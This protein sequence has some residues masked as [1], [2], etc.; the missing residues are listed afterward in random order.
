MIS[1]MARGTSL[2]VRHIS[3]NKTENTERVLVCTDHKF[4]KELVRKRV[5]VLAIKF[6][7]GS[8]SKVGFVLHHMVTDLSHCIANVLVRGEEVV[9][10]GS[11]PFQ[12]TGQLLRNSLEEAHDDANRRRL[13]IVT[14]LFHGG[15]IR[16]SVM[17]VKLH[18]FPY[19][20][21]D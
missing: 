6:G 16:N 11:V 4:G 2:H 17:A 13:H 9:M 10:F 21:Q 8:I 7:V 19:S 3:S 15:S 18:A 14:E 20:Q 5:K 1:S 12:E